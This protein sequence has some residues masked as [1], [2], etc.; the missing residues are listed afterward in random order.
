MDCER[1]K[2]LWLRFLCHPAPGLASRVPLDPD[3][4]P[5]TAPVSTW[6]SARLRRDAACGADQVVVRVAPDV[7]RDPCRTRR[8]PGMRRLPP[9]YPV[10]RTATGV[11]TGN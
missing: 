9:W 5:A 3:P 11:W 10:H 4:A 7:A 1:A 6:V 8:P 2:A